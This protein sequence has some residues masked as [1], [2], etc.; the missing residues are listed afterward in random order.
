MTHSNTTI[1]NIDQQNQTDFNSNLTS[2][3]NLHE[4]LNQIH[5]SGSR[6]YHL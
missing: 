1:H 3:L 4:P 6:V 5:L 2:L